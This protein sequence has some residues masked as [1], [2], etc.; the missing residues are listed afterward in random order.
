MGGRC[1]QPFY[2][3]FPFGEQSK[4]CSLVFHDKHALNHA[5]LTLELKDNL[6]HCISCNGVTPSKKKKSKGNLK[7]VK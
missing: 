6:S 4:L 2:F 5:M 7:Y 3:L 1:L